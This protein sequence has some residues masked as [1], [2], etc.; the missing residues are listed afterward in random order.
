MLIS[1]CHNFSFPNA[2]GPTAYK[3][4]ADPVKAGFPSLDT[5]A[6]ILIPGYNN[7][8]AASEASFETITA[9]M[10]ERWFAGLLWPGEDK[11]I[12]YA[13]AV[14]N[15]DRAAWRLSDILQD[16][17]VVHA[18]THSLGA[19]VILGALAQGAITLGDVFV[20]APAVDDNSLDP[21]GEF[22]A[23]A[24]HCKSLNIFYS[25]HDPVLAHDYPLGD[26]KLPLRRALGLDGPRNIKALPPNVRVFNC[27]RFVTTHGGYRYAPEFFAAWRAVLAGTAP[28]GLTV[29]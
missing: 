19:R 21:G 9:A 16:G 26:M 24:L 22:E 10:P 8:A 14:G 18:E 5:G 17:N 25:Q 27:S 20:T 4:G 3:A 1:I 11:G 2:F 15:A 13:L 28:F 6:T 12:L 7:T 23:A 29:L